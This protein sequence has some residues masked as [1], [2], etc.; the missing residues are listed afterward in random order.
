MIMPSS[1]Y[2]TIPFVLSN[3]L[4]LQPKTVLDV[5]A[6]FGKLGF[7]LREYLEGWKDRVFPEQW[8]VRI[9]ALEGF[10]R[11]AALPWY[12]I[13]YDTII[14]QDIRT[15][16]PTSMYDLVVFGDVI[17]HLEKADAQQAVARIRAKARAAIISLPIGDGWLGNTVVAGND[18]E[19]H[20]SSW[21]IKDVATL[22]P[23]WGTKADQ[24]IDAARGS[25]YLARL[26]V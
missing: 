7:L 17:E 23:G 2:R 24:T 8:R 16:K 18:L 6:G 21:E 20:R 25:I 11:Y 22:F 5:G 4:R 9:T 15:F 13:V 10:E 12:E 14:E 1:D 26:E 3:A 19:K